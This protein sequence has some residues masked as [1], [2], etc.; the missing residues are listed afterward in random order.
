M[1]GRAAKHAGKMPALPDRG[2]EREFDHSKNQS[3][4]TPA[5]AIILRESKNKAKG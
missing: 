4:L 5:A 2:I 1:N 3:G